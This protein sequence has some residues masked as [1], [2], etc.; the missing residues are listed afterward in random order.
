MAVRPERLAARHPSGQVA[1]SD[2]FTW[3][4]NFR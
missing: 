4:P 3:S 1:C 2:R